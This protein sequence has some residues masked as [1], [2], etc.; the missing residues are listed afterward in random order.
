MDSLLSTPELSGLGAVAGLVSHWTYFIRGEHHRRTRLYLL[1]AVAMP[2]VIA[3]AQVYSLHLDSRVAVKATAIFVTSF[4][5]SLWTSVL[6]YR[7]FF[8]PLRRFPGPMLAK[9]SKFYHACL[10]WKKNNFEIL[11]ELHE[12]YGPVLRIGMSSV[13][14]HSIQGS[15]IQSHLLRAK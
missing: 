2:V 12:K 14:L 8:H 13:L 1:L 9:T 5:F 4:W 11:Q 7:L 10:V 6:A 3:T 15:L